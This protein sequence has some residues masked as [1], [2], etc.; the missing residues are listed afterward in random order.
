MAP[1]DSFA[2]GGPL[3]DRGKDEIAT[4]S[5]DKGFYDVC[6][7]T[8]TKPMCALD[9][10]GGIGGQ[11]A[12]SEPVAIVGMGMR[13]PGKARTS[14]DFWNLLANKE[15]GCIRVPEDRYNS[16]GFYHPAGRPGSICTQHGHF[17]QEDI[18][19][20]DNEFFSI[21]PTDA[22]NMDPQQRMLLEVVWECM[23]NAGQVGWQG[24]DVGCFVGVFGESWLD[25]TSRD[26]QRPWDGQVNSTMD[27]ALA[28]RVSYE[29]DLRG[30]SLTIQ[31]ACS[32]GLVA[33]HA[34]CQAISSGSCTSAIVAGTNLII[35]PTMMMA[36]TAEGVISSSGTSKTFDAA[37]DGYGRGEAITAIL[38]KKVDRAKADNDRIRATVR[39]TATNFDGK[40]ADMKTPNPRSHEQLIRQTYDV[41]GI[42]NFSETAFVE[43][44]G[45]GTTVGDPLEAGAI[46]EV[47]GEKGVMITSVKPN[48]GH[49]EGA[50]GITSIIKAV[51]SIENEQIPPNI[52]FSM[53]NPRIPFQK[54]HLQVPVQLTEWPADRRKRV[55]ING[56]GIGGVNA[57]AIIE[58]SN[59]CRT[60]RQ[61]TTHRSTNG[62]KLIV[63]SGKSCSAL[64]QRISQFEGYL[65][66]TSKEIRDI[67]YTMCQRR[68]H[69]KYRAFAI[70]DGR[71][72]V[73]FSSIEKSFPSTSRLAFVFTGQGAQWAGMAKD[74]YL[75]SQCFRNSVSKL[76]KA[77]QSLP[78]PPEWKII[79]LF[80]YPEKG[81]QINTPGL[82]QPLCTALQIGLV[83]MLAE[84]NVHPAAVLGHSSGEIAAAY[85]AGALTA[86]SAIIVAYY[87][88]KIAEK[89]AL[90]ST[91]GG[92]AA[93]GLGREEVSPYL[94]DGVKVACENSPR[95][96]TLSG[97]SNKLNK[98][99][100]NIQAEKKD[101]FCRPLRVNVA[102][103]SRD[104]EYFGPEYESLLG[105]GVQ[106]GGCRIPLYSTVTGQA[107]PSSSEMRA[108][109]WR[110]N[111][112]K[113]V[114][115]SQ[116]VMALLKGQEIEAIVEVGPH[117]AL[118]GPLRELFAAENKVLRYIPTVVRD[119]SPL[120]S[121][122]KTA[123]NLHA[124]GVPIE[125]A[126]VNGIA[127]E[128][129]IVTD[130]P[131]Y[132][133]QHGTNFWD[134]SRH[135]KEWRS[136]QH[137]NHELLGSRVFETTSLEPA[138]RNVIR[139]NDVPWLRD[140]QV[141]NDIVFPCSAYV[142]MAGE[143][144]RQISGYGNY[145][146]RNIFIKNALL[147]KETESVELFTSLRPVRL[148]D[149]LDSAWWSFSVT[150]WN[151]T[152]WM[153]HCA[154]EAKGVAEGRRSTER[155]CDLARHVPSPSWYRSVRN[156]GLRYGPSFQCLK[157][158]SASPTH[159]LAAATVYEEKDPY[160]NP[161]PLHP[162]TI[163]QCIVLSAAA[164][165][166]GLVRKL[167]EAL[168][169]QSIDEIFIGQGSS[170]ISAKGTANR[171]ESGTVIGNAVADSAGIV[172]MQL[173][174]VLLK[175]VS[176]TE[177]AQDR[178]TL[179]GAQMTWTPLIDLASYGQLMR[180]NSHRDSKVLVEKLAVSCILE[181]ACQM[182]TRRASSEHLRKF[183]SW[184]CF[185][186]ERFARGDYSVLRETGALLA[187][188]SSIRR[189]MIGETAAK[190]KSGQFAP[191]VQAILSIYNNMDD[192]LEERV[193]GLDLLARD[194]CLT[195]IYRTIGSTM[196]LGDFFTCYGKSR[197]NMR[198][199]EIGA[200]T[201]G[202]TETALRALSLASGVRLFSTYTF[203]DISPGFFQAAKK[204][205]SGYEGISYHVLDISRDPIEQG[206]AAEQYDLV[207]AANVLHA[208]PSLSRTLRNVRKLVAPGGRLFL[209]E[210]CGD[211]VA[212][213][214]IMGSL[215]GWWLGDHDQRVNSPYVEPERWH[216]ELRKSGFRGAQSVVY[217]D[218]KPFHQMAHIVSMREEIDPEKSV[219]LLH[220]GLIG[221]TG[222]S[223]QQSFIHRGYTVS[224][225]NLG[226]DLPGNQSV[227]SLL[228]LDRPFL[229]DISKDNWN[230]IQG[231]LSGLT[232]Q[233][234]LWVT[235]ES[236]LQ[237][238][239]PRY[240][241]ILGLAR[242][243]RMEASLDFA[244]L[245]IDGSSQTAAKGIVDVYEHFDSFRQLPGADVDF[246]YILTGSTIQ[247]PRYLPCSLNSELEATPDP[248]DSKVLTV[249]KYGLLEA[250]RWVA[251]ETTS[252][253]RDLVEVTPRFLGLNF[254]DLLVAMG[255]VDDSP[256]SMGIEASGTVTNVGPEVHDLIVGDSVV[257]LS[258]GGCFAS[259]IVVPRKLCHKIP[260]N[261]PLEE[262]ATM[263]CVFSTAIHSLLN[264]ARIEK[265]QTILIHSGAGGVGQAAIQISQHV[266]ATVY[267]TVGDD[268]KA[269]Y[270][271]EKY[272]I[273]SDQIFNS[274]SPSFL[275]G[276][277][278]ATRG[279]G[280]DVVLNSLSGELLHISWQ[281]VAQYG[282]MV[283]I[284]K[285]DIL[286]NGR[287][288]MNELL[289]NR[290][291]FGVDMAQIVRD[292]PDLVQGLL[293]QWF[294]FHQQHAIQSIRPIHM[295]EA[296]K[297]QE[298]FRL[299]QRGK[300]IG[301][302][303]IRMPERSEVLSLA[304]TRSKVEPFEEGAYL[305]VGGLGGIGRPIATWL[306]EN[307]ARHLV[308]F[309]PSA[310]RSQEHKAFFD[311]IRAHGAE[312]TAIS[313]DVR[314]LCDVQQIVNMSPKPI[315]GVIHLAMILQDRSTIGMA[316]DAWCAAVEPKVN[317]TWNLHSVFGGADL[318][319]FVLMSSIGGIRGYPGQANY[320]AANSF[321]NAFAHYRH[322]L[323]LP[324]SV[325]N[326]GVM[327]EVGFV[328]RTPLVLE[329]FR[330]QGTHIL[331]IRDLLDAMELT[332]GNQLPKHHL[333]S[334]L[335]LTHLNV[336]F[337][338][339]KTGSAPRLRQDVRLSLVRE[340]KQDTASSLGNTD[341]PLKDFLSSIAADSSVLADPTS[342]EILTKEISR[343]FCSLL[344]I[345][346]E[347][348]DPDR[349]ISDLG[350]DSLVKV[351]I[352]KWWRRHLDLDIS[353]FQISNAPSVTH[354][355]ESAVQSLGAKF[356]P[357]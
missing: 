30:P 95:S 26:L 288:S 58:S 264:V 201:G 135:V 19:H 159:P 132:P 215:P 339:M 112:E 338:T 296:T 336:G 114:L 293:R 185:Q 9:D 282:T 216:E 3:I 65:A 27:F 56:F 287:L 241:M 273:H 199:L 47:F 329:R 137:A 138:W 166:N 226:Q 40:T 162:T 177:D 167:G 160:N 344:S 33:L 261:L 96:V 295:F 229:H 102:Y 301:K 298:G 240:G 318:R 303:V 198:I 151:G 210:V 176:V 203:T 144:V 315:A 157:N 140:H 194:D 230:N 189:T 190:L 305:I 31:T 12:S 191:Y 324:A 164:S 43:C 38:L 181:S 42:H 155:I 248:G 46:A 227:V 211:M 238:T 221:N 268:E 69:L 85:S 220:D 195:D 75:L 99:T 90:R 328:A 235:L 257:L 244:T 136:R 94:M 34:A 253:T 186:V 209:Q 262:A 14:E 145:I 88:G 4:T 251:Q 356:V 100:E 309:S 237:S 108:S 335:G 109:Y 326:L 299:M 111:L 354:L 225:C 222:K 87:R 10:G 312:V 187:T 130:I 259:P 68:E 321:L 70:A 214:Y 103:H 105:R 45:T 289:R 93:I 256:T 278:Q 143:A 277:M 223:I 333:S 172:V 71:E 239:D 331:T 77:L 59:Y 320:A 16:E 131:L 1:F 97:D 297:P 334:T 266:G 80:S 317:G 49:S 280:V 63:L 179:A 60:E 319:F 37:A 213:S 163:D 124:F 313:G 18:R 117:S 343:M 51:L 67:A 284:G 61:R 281:C 170:H 83:D 353:I 245:E 5:E 89:A 104:M 247:V 290:A 156:I 74:L 41:A 351:E 342:L 106:S 15:S 120:C 122:M 192:I 62:P 142:A 217:D 146:L 150:S 180:P 165:C 283:E 128:R 119:K 212:Q 78:D 6:T 115:F 82:S 134:E 84:W 81:Y 323:G 258:A 269:N 7:R 250:M 197:P 350:V 304:P 36:M 322:S 332:V 275:A 276:V 204:R 219:T 337:V 233:G 174:N 265:G 22:G 86:E 169:P 11:G 98:I 302:I 327:D 255:I 314:K 274:R 44:H 154:G 200:G 236:Q 161:Y 355:I 23:E 207:I 54:A 121:L 126:A 308:F 340:F 310:G 76:D 291:F 292:K 64:K 306:V 300:H 286:G 171:A 263:P 208:T 8:T 133:W 279:R 39:A 347:E 110:G 173:R 232:S 17:L 148:T 249:G 48:V 357:H 57:H 2:P 13:L 50:S 20:F 153:Q 330:Q 224:W 141:G 196:D 149:E 267:V 218:Q 113:P 91:K 285:R 316:Y 231:L 101:A 53:P 139:L 116:A 152:H 72:S 32:S 345:T 202:M 184:I 341:A 243:I 205:F 346:K 352:R 307:G 29:Y 228:E 123:G 127:G 188:S 325:I 178:D 52:N 79:D 206:F 252:L 25:I 24:T 242:T 175:R 272:G 28:N 182:S 118:A 35:T 107:M 348:F 294:S 270:L 55:S 92:M 73:S 246:E 271:T 193:H 129:N 147:L 349:A 260:D 183:Q 168:I 311:E 158:I 234:V 254:R 66:R 125:L 21:S